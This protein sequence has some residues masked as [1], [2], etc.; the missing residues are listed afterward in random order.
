MIRLT[1]MLSLIV[2][3]S[4]LLK[5]LL[6]PSDDGA[7][8]FGA[9]RPRHIFL[10][11]GANIGDTTSGF[12]GLTPPLSPEFE[13]PLFQFR[14]L[15]SFWEVHLFEG[16]PRFLL[17]LK[18]LQRTLREKHSLIIHCPVAVSAA[19]QP[20]VPFYLDEV[21]PRENY[22][23]SSLFRSHPNVGRT[24]QVPA[25]GLSSFFREIGATKND[26]ILVKMDIE[27]AEY[28]VLKEILLDGSWQLISH[29]FLKF[30]YFEPGSQDRAA[31]LRW[32]FQN[33]TLHL[34]NWIEEHY[35]GHPA[36]AGISP[37]G[38]NPL[39]FL[40]KMARGYF[41][42][43]P[44]EILAIIF[45]FLTRN[46]HSNCKKVSKRF[47]IVGLQTKPKGIH[48]NVAFLGHV[49]CGKS[50][51]VGHL[52]HLLGV[53]DPKTLESYERSAWE[54]GKASFKYAWFSD[55]TQTERE[56][57]ITVQG[58]ILPRVQLADGLSVSF[59]DLPGHRDFIKN[60]MRMLAC[61]DVHVL[62]VAAGMGEFEASFAP[63]GCARMHA[64]ISF[65]QNI[66]HQLAHRRGLAPPLVVALNKMDDRSI[67]TGAGHAAQEIRFAEVTQELSELLVKFHGT[68]L[69]PGDLGEHAI[70]CVPISAWQGENLTSTHNLCPWS[71]QPPHPLLARP[72]ERMLMY[73]GP[74][75]LEAIVHRAGRLGEGAAMGPLLRSRQLVDAPVLDALRFQVLGTHPREPVLLGMVKSGEVHVG[76][77]LRFVGVRLSGALL[78]RTGMATQ[79]VG[80]EQHRIEPSQNPVAL[81]A[82]VQ[83]AGTEG[84]PVWLH[85][86]EGRP[87][88]PEILR[89]RR[90]D[91]TARHCAEV[92]AR[93]AS[94]QLDREAQS[95]AFSGDDVGLGL[96]DLAIRVAG[97]L[98]DPSRAL[99]GLPSR[100]GCRCES[101]PGPIAQDYIAPGQEML[102]HVQAG[103]AACRVVELLY[104][105]GRRPASPRRPTP[106]EA[107]QAVRG[108]GRPFP[109]PRPPA[110]PVRP[111]IR[112]KWRS[113]SFLELCGASTRERY[114]LAGWA[115]APRSIARGERGIIRLVITQPIFVDLWRYY[116][117]PH[118]PTGVPTCGR[119]PSDVAASS[120]FGVFLLREGR[121]I[122]G[123][124][125]VVAFD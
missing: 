59:V 118:G 117:A 11:L 80:W 32:I 78:A 58:R 121:S 45:T 41:D 9:P 100:S 62:V 48:V 85:M 29:L 93:V 20:S 109:D 113:N 26:L 8:I 16:N 122:L 89:R 21:N 81:T 17:R 110:P 72:V 123:I 4:V 84:R 64:L 67:N 36:G 83:A 125:K 38:W 119:G 68:R 116:A 91:Q 35:K 60:F 7:E 98:H 56:R 76:Q 52:A 101:C 105:K 6:S 95:S 14:N 73:R 90:F 65:A 94:I 108:K 111:D 5:I 12:L 49:D 28:D 86:H 106:D 19:S 25:V 1:C 82:S 70:P 77:V 39:S 10:D 102:L 114:E 61:A 27:G 31:A 74:S 23:G 104:R 37:L 15:S 87:I 13:E 24:V 120:P 88:R 75:L 55:R 22:W 66:H 124:G 2:V 40:R 107:D 54:M 69:S 92:R 112:A 79:L 50:T 33:T 57:G 99:T 18:A 71:G 97:C 30:H 47:L 3:L 44:D 43:V 53:L 51:L 115:Y 34:H 103:Q 42:D 96:V 63:D 46:A